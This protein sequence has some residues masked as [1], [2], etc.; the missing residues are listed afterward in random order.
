MNRAVPIR[1]T[2]HVRG[3][4]RNLT[5]KTSGRFLIG[6]GKES[7]HR[8]LRGSEAA[9]SQTKSYQR[10]QHHGAQKKFLRGALQRAKSPEPFPH[11]QEELGA[12]RSPR[13]GSGV[14]SGWSG[15]IPVRRRI[16]LEAPGKLRQCSANPSTTATCAC[17]SRPI[18]STVPSRGSATPILD[19]EGGPVRGP[20]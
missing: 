11:Q 1:G 20:V 7:L 13:A 5:R 17:L 4:R 16:P 10:Q 14:P 12:T 6:I 2:H 19:Q 3:Y 15:A 18:R 8:S 9:P